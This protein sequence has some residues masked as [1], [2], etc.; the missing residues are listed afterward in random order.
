MMVQKHDKFEKFKIGLFEC[1]LYT[2]VTEYESQFIAS[3]IDINGDNHWI[4]FN[5]ILKWNL[6]FGI[7]R[8]FHCK[9]FPFHWNKMKM[10]QL[11]K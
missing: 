4:G 9:I 2:P 5:Y 6:Y 11:S 8:Y 1:H 10:N 3:G 7:N